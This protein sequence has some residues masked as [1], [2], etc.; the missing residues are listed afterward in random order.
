MS[1]FGIANFKLAIEKRIGV[2]NGF[3]YGSVARAR[4]GCAGTCAKCISL[5]SF[6]MIFRFSGGFREVFQNFA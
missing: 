3:E 6:L 5:N 1:N 4:M 2:L